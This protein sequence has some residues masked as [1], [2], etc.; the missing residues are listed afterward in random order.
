M[1]CIKR[2]FALQC[3]EFAGI[4]PPPAGAQVF[5]GERPIIDA[6]SLNLAQPNAAQLGAGGMRGRITP[7]LNAPEELTG[8]RWRNIDEH[9]N[10]LNGGNKGRGPNRFV[11]MDLLNE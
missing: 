6:Q 11:K 2:M 9:F 7:Y 3:Q 8:S 10:A 4:N 5:V 1:V